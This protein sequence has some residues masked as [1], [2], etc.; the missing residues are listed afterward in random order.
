MKPP[1]WSRCSEVQLWKYLAWHMAGAKIPAVLVGGAVAA[2]YSKGAYQSGD[3]DFVTEAADDT[4]LTGLFHSLGFKRMGRHFKHPQCAH[5]LVE[6]PPGPLG[7][8]SNHRIK[9]RLVRHH[10][11][12]LKILSPTDCVC[13]R[14]ASF[15]HFK[16]RDAL[17]QAVL[18]AQSVRVNHA[19]IRKWCADE[20]G[21]VQ[22]QEW[23]ERIKPRHSKRG[24]AKRSG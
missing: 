6:F 5:L 17:D 2:I 24:K 10:Q 8:G 23:L 12:M 7:I 1:D 20:G 3:L 16:S 11:R 13:D 18:V 4:A 19:K 9:P 21:L 22:Y 15:I 14:L